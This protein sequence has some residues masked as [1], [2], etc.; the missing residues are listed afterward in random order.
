MHTTV[1][2]VY[3]AIS[4]EIKKKKHLRKQNGPPP[5]RP[6]TS[7]DKEKLHFFVHGAAATPL[8]PMLRMMII[9]IIIIILCVH[10]YYVVNRTHTHVYYYILCKEIHARALRHQLYAAYTVWRNDA[11]HTV[12]LIKRTIFYNNIMFNQRQQYV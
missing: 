1:P 3:I 4:N 2:G 8:K 6:I 12:S 11:V 10:V 7:F 9:I 5:C